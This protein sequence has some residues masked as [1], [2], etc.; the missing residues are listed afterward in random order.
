MMFHEICTV[1]VKRVFSKFTRVIICREKHL[2][3]P[4]VVMNMLDLQSQP[5]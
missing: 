4:K 2:F 1:M 5:I 3:R